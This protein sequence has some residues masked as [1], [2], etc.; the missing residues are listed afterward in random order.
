MIQPSPAAVDAPVALVTGSGR[1]LGAAIAARLARA[2]HAI[3][4]H[5]SHDGTPEGELVEVLSDHAPGHAWFT[6]DLSDP[7]A[8]DGLVRRVADHFGRPVTILV[9]N[10]S[11]FSAMDGAETTHADL[12][13][14]LAVNL[15]AP[16]LLSQAMAAGLPAGV[17]GS[18]V[19]IL[20]Q[21]IRQ[22]PRDQL[23]YTV[24]KQALAEATRTLATTYAPH[25]RVNAVA[26]GLTLATAEYGTQQMARLEQMMPLA[27]L[28]TTTEIA[29]AVAFLVGAPSVT[30]QTLFVD[31][32]AALTRY[33]RDFVHL[34][35]D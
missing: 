19:N 34:A 22:P 31:G 26:P 32:G 33:D 2:G 4:L 16:V 17:Q 35:R 23:G 14:H 13:A 24:S 21:R 9:N 7:T 20:D 1:R 27:R 29:D 28:A 5:G 25:V 12:M 15:V 3:A 30:G 11:R 6:A 8:T 18:V 10:A